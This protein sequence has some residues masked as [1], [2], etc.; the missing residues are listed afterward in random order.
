MAQR[1]KLGFVLLPLLA[2]CITSPTAT[3]SAAVLI[4]FLGDNQAGVVNT[5]LPK[6][7]IVEV[8]DASGIPVQGATVTWTVL[9]GGGSVSSSSVDSDVNGEA[10]VNWTLGS[11]VG[12][13][14]LQASV[15]GVQPVTFLAVASPSGRLTR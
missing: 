15:T 2:G 4:K 6:P 11:T 14:D 1:M 12:E 7:C 9:T 3:S 8:V 10:P 5:T 13:Q